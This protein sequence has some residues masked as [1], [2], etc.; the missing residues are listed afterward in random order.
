MYRGGLFCCFLTFLTY[1]CYNTV[2]QVAA[3]TSR[4]TGNYTEVKYITPKKGEL[5][6]LMC[7]TVFTW[8]PETALPQSYL[9]E[10][11]HNVMSCCSSV[12]FKYAYTL[13][14]QFC[15]YTP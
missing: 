3:V 7:V 2:P 6:L 15:F 1:I 8:L 9:S 13:E 12:S 14:V 5:L 11:F 4:G 10:C